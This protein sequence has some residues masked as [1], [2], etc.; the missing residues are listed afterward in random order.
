MLG[1]TP[2]LVPMML[3][4]LQSLKALSRRPKLD[5]IRFGTMMLPPLDCEV[6]ES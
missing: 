4:L 6:E 2:R 3:P 5:V 1:V